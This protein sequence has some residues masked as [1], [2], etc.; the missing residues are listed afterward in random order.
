MKWAMMAMMCLAVLAS[1]PTCADAPKCPDEYGLLGGP[2]A[3][4]PQVTTSGVVVCG[5]EAYCA[6]D[7]P[8]ARG[9]A[10]VVRRTRDPKPGRKEGHLTQRACRLDTGFMRCD[11]EWYGYECRSA[12]PEGF[13]GKRP[14]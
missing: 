14:W 9:R 8:G 3:P 6:V 12:W 4:T 10:L 13:A 2:G 11:P 1:A 5:D 7:G